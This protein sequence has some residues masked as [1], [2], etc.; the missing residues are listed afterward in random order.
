M[1]VVV[2][3]VVTVPVVPDHGA[4]NIK[5]PVDSSRMPVS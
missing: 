4:H 3:V 2:E 1:V 5:T